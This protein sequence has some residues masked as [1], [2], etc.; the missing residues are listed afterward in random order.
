MRKSEKVNSAMTKLAAI[1]LLSDAITF[2][3]QDL[4]QTLEFL[5]PLPCR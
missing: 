3:S 4:L 2:S 5:Q 1:S